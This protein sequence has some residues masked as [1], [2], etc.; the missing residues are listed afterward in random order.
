MSIRSLIRT[1]VNDALGSFGL[2]LRRKHDTDG[3]LRHVTF[4]TV[5]DG[6][7]NVGDYTAK[8]R[9]RMPAAEIHTFEPNPDLYGNLHARFASD[10]RITCYDRA[11]SNAD[12]AVF[13]RVTEDHFSSSL[14][15]QTEK[16]ST[17]QEKAVEVQAIK[18]DSWLRDRQIARPALL[19]LD[20]EGNELAALQGAERLLD[21][22]DYIELEVT[23]MDVRKDQPQLRDIL[24]FLHDRGFRLIDILPGIL[25]PKTGSAVWADAIFKRV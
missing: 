21:Q 9:E 8:M 24:N 22:I 19:K 2:E 6:G 11:I 7:A 23:F 25:D 17:L 1:T 10:A 20:V 18:L 15:E 4:G 12:G 3:L 14:L 5:I 13:F 16:P